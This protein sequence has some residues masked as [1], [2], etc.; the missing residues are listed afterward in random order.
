MKELSLSDLRLEFVRRVL[1]Q[2]ASITD[3][4]E[5]FG[6]SRV[7]GYKILSRF[8]SEGVAGLA[9]RSRA[10][11]HCP[12]S[13]D[14]ILI[15]QILA[16][17]GL[18][19]CRYWGP[20][21]V[22]AHLQITRPDIGWPA[23]STFAAIFKR[24]GHVTQRRLRGATPNAGK[25]LTQA[26]RPNHVWCID[27]KGDFQLLDG[28]NCYPLTVTDDETRYLIR[29]QS[30]SDTSGALAWPCFVGAF[31]ELGLPEKI[32]SDN[33]APFAAVC[34]T[35]LTPLS[36]KFMKL[37]IGHERMRPS[38]P[39]QNARHE[40]M[41][42]TL[43]A[44]TTQPPSAYAGAQQD[45]FNI[46]RDEYNNHRPHEGIGMKRPGDLYTSSPR[47]Y[48]EFL[49]ALKCEDGMHAIKVR[50]NG[51]IR[52]RG[53]ELY[54]GQVLAG[55]HVTLDHFDEGYHALYVG[56][57]PM[58]VVDERTKAFLKPKVAKQYLRTLRGIEDKG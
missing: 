37:G 7:T 1:D 38:T 9:D 17:K 56:N 29:C 32:R 24:H 45:R 23:S 28:Y 30:M 10:P 13:V 31:R 42:K 54:V 52:W 27:Y 2:H 4:C 40:R 8:E 43:K 5:S 26:S 22:R 47:P 51:S 58:A 53:V 12:H 25:P 46:W 19:M 35:G 33:G 34:L 48:P 3:A 44:E 36:L 41:H 50:P 57:Q 21:K 6:I 20:K 49:P 55:E 14:A 18:P 11:I 15:D 39:T 16:A